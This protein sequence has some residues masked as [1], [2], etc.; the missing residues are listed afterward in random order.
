[1][2]AQKDEFAFRQKQHDDALKAQESAGQ[3]ARLRQEQLD[4]DRRADN[5]RDL[6]SKRHQGFR[7]YLDRGYSPE[8]A[9]ELSGSEYQLPWKDEEKL[10]IGRAE[11]GRLKAAGV[12]KPTET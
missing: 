3:D 11:V 7:D 8:S 9:F 4:A 6:R 2:L 12:I 10:A 1:Q 5:E